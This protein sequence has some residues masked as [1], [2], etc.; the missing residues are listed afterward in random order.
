MSV[1]GA[2]TVMAPAIVSLSFGA[3]T[4]ATWGGVGLIVGVWVLA[5]AATGVLL[6]LAGKSK[7]RGEK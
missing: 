6:Y 2:F 7:G 5:L 3:A 1:W 4:F